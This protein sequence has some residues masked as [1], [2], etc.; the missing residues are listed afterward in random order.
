MLSNIRKVAQGSIVLAAAAL[1]MILLTRLFDPP[2]EKLSAA[3]PSDLISYLDSLGLPTDFADGETLFSI[4][5]GESKIWFVREENLINEPYSGGPGSNLVRG[6]V[7][8]SPKDPNYF[9][10]TPIQIDVRELLDEGGIRAIVVSQMLNIEQYPFMLITPHTIGDIKPGSSGGKFELEI[11][12]EMTIRDITNPMTLQVSGSLVTAD[13]LR[14]EIVG[15][16]VLDDFGI[17]P[18]DLPFLGTDVESGWLRA[19]L[20]VIRGEIPVAEIDASYVSSV[21][22]QATGVVIHDLDASDGYTLV[23]P[24]F[25]NLNYLIDQ[26][27]EVVFSWESAYPAFAAYLLEDGSLLRSAFIGKDAI[28]SRFGRGH[29]STGR[30]ERLDLNGDIS[31]FFEYSTE[32]Y[33]LHHDI[34][35][36][37]NGNILMSAWEVVSEEVAIN[38]GRNPS[39][40]DTEIWMDMLLEVNQEGQIV[41]EWHVADHLIQ[42]LDPALPNYGEIASHPERIDINAGRDWTRDWTH[43]NAVD[44]HPLLDQIMISVMGFNEFWIIDHSTTSEE[45][46]SHSGGK[47]GA[48]GDLLYRW[49]N[50]QSYGAGNHKDQQLFGFHDANWIIPGAPGEGNILIF[51]N[52]NNRPDGNYSSVD[53]ITLPVSEAGEYLLMTDPS[54]WQEQVIWS[55]TAE[56]PFEFQAL[57]IS[58]AQRLVNGNTFITSGP[59]G[60][61]IEISPEGRILWWYVSPFGGSMESGPTQYAGDDTNENR[62]PGDR[63]VTSIFRAFRYPLNYPGVVRIVNQQ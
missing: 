53:E 62:G 20:V 48:G 58:G 29:G 10:L 8:F 1:L 24:M 44:Y 40:V 35:P 14:L 59:S 23:A 28:A 26:S 41:W 17:E 43:V 3:D 2:V 5:P 46:A 12:G 18:P 32:Q 50:P 4:V 21:S 37:P 30:V 52:G 61:L 38:L 19:E 13:E 7:Q 45:A 60:E 34:E 16:I 22:P 6:Y 9:N 49:G 54:V 47:Y 25:S 31:W 33:L 27:G 51:N 63:I 55:Y 39:T 42:D 36:L 11:K 15:E 56:D 57:N